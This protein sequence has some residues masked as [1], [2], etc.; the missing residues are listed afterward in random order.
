M[1]RFRLL[2][3]CLFVLFA[4]SACS[5]SK[6]VEYLAIGNQVDFSLLEDQYGHPF[7]HEDVMN[8]VLYVN[9]MRAKKITRDALE[10]IDLSC[11]DG[12]RV[13]Y[14]ADISGMPGLIST[15]IAVPRMRNYPYPI[16]LDRSG[17]ATDALPVQDDAVTLL[18]VEQQ[19]ITRIEFLAGATALLPR[20]QAECGPA[21]QQVAVR[22]GG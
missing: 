22:S 11:L 7:K 21:A 5:Q 14:L 13:V 12:G 15:L 19:A 9:S 2:L 17:V 10:G 1:F 20:L 3:S 18:T 6:P 16:W 4:T 8:T